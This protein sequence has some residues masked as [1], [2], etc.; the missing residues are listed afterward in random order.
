MD[1]LV[2]SLLFK[3]RDIWGTQEDVVTLLLKP[4]RQNLPF[5]T[6]QLLNRTKWYVNEIRD[7]F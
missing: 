1:I 2:L 6:E 5:V 7:Y 4:T 3:I